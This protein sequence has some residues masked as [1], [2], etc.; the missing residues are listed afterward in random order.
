M[1]I[2]RE[3][4]GFYPGS[5]EERPTS[6]RG[7]KYCISLHQSACVGVTSYERGKE[8]QVSKENEKCH[9]VAR[10]HLPSPCLLFY[11]LKWRP[12]LQKTLGR[13]L[14]EEGSVDTVEFSITTCLGHGRPSPSHR[15]D[16]DD[17]TVRHPGCYGGRAIPCS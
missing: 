2:Q 15:G 8:S 17:G 12:R 16:V 7:R 5:S 13:C 1:V 3:Y 6:S 14:R 9:S 10:P 11:R 4:M